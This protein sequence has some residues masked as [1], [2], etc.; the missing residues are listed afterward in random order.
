MA[1][2]E[3]KLV[4][5]P[6]CPYVQRARGILLE[7]GIVHDVTYIDLSEPPVWF[8]DISPL[9]KVLAI[10]EY[11]DEITPGTLHPDDAFE[12]ALNRAWIEFGNDV[13]DLTYRF[14]TS[15]DQDVYKQLDMLLHERFEILDEKLVNKPFFNGEKFCIIDMVFAPLLRFHFAIAEHGKTNF[16]ADAPEVAAWG[17]KLLERPSVINSV[18]NDFDVLLDNYLRRQDSIF[19]ATLS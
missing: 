16:L 17:K 2:P 15:N 7:K 9:E 19:A 14:F 6:L 5:F 13:L 10:C 1:L 18:P 8:Y 12:R 11:L 3:F 4:S